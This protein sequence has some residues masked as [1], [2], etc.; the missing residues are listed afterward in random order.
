MEGLYIIPCSGP[1][2]SLAGVVIS[3]LFWWLALA[4]VVRSPQLEAI[5]RPGFCDTC[6]PSSC[7]RSP[8]RTL[9]SKQGQCYRY[10]PK[11][12]DIAREGFGVMIPRSESLSPSY[13]ASLM[14]D[15]TKTSLRNLGRNFLNGSE[16]C[17]E[18]YGYRMVVFG[19]G[20]P[21]QDCSNQAG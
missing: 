5:A 14:N 3:P 8:G 6:T 17:L 7:A 12:H 1:S 19:V 16:G 18:Y 21:G 15:F 2:E 9:D 20:P 11:V 4:I 10:H 13:R